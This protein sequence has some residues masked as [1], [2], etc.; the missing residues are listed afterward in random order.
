MLTSKAPDRVL[1]VMVLELTT[2]GLHGDHNLSDM[3]YGV[4][5][6]GPQESRVRERA[7]ARFGL[8]RG[9]GRFLLLVPGGG[10][11]V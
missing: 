9:H 2:A 5:R 3:V 10:R 11:V 7:F 6:S 8:P 1:V 4:S